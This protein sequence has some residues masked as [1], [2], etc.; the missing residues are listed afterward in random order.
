[1]FINSNT[2][3][4]FVLGFTDM[5]KGIDS[6]CL[7]VASNEN[8]NVLDGSLYVFC[9]KNKKSIKVLYW[10]KNGFSLYQKRLEN[11]KFYWPSDSN[12]TIEMSLTELRWFLDGL[13]PISCYG[14]KKISY[15]SII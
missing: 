15:K 9:S 3:V 12:D 10:D 8:L 2:K 11:D 13:N 7:Q 6:L 5:R 4:Y 14:Y 1:M